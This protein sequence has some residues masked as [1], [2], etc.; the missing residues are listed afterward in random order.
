MLFAIFLRFL[1][2][3]GTLLKLFNA[4]L[5]GLKKRAR[6][7]VLHLSTSVKALPSY[8][9]LCTCLMSTSPIINF[10]FCG[11][12]LGHT[13]CLHAVDSFFFSPSFTTLSTSSCNLF[14]VFAIETVTSA[15]LTLLRLCKLIINMKLRKNHSWYSGRIISDYTA[16]NAFRSRRAILYIYKSQFMP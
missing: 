3:L 6:I 11:F 4:S 10:N 14:S 1:L 12:Y 16:I 5:S 13:F 7:S 9:K 8:I 15:Y 2:F